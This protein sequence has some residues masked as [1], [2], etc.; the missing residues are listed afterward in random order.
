MSRIYPG[1]PSGS[2]SRNRGGDLAR[3]GSELDL[4]APGVTA[5]GV[6]AFAT[7][8][9]DAREL[10]RI[11][12]I[13]G[14][15]ASEVTRNQQIQLASL[16][17]QQEFAQDNARLAAMQTRAAQGFGVQR[18][19]ERE[20]L[21]LDQIARDTQ[22]LSDEAIAERA[23]Q[24][25]R[26]EISGL[27]QDAALAFG[28]FGTPRLVDALTRRRAALQEQSQRDTINLTLA[29]APNIRTQEQ[30]SQ[31]VDALAAASPGV[32]RTV[33]ANTVGERLLTY[34]ATT[35][36]EADFAN[37]LAMAP[38]VDPIFVAQQRAALGTRQNAVV[39]QTN[40]RFDDELGTGLINARDGL[41]SFDNL[42]QDFRRHWQG[43]VGNE[44]LNAGLERIRSAKKA[45]ATEVTAQAKKIAT[46][47]W[48]ADIVEQAA[49]AMSTALATGGLARVPASGVQQTIDVGGEPVDVSMTYNE[50]R[51]L[52]TERVMESIKRTSPTPEDAFRRQYQTLAENDTE[53][54]AWRQVL[55][56][57]ASVPATS[58]TTTDDKPIPIPVNLQ[59][60]YELYKAMTA[61]DANTATRD[62]H[63]DDRTGRFYDD[64][65]AAMQYVTGGN[66]ASAYQLAAKAERR[67]F[68]VGV[69]AEREEEIRNAASRLDPKGL[70]NA[71]EV[72]NPND[73]R[74]NIYRA[75]KLSMDGMGLAP[76][77][78][79]QHAIANVTGKYAAINGWAVPTNR[80]TVPPNIDSIAKRVV[81]EFVKANPDSG[82]DA[83]DLT[84]MPLGPN[85]R[86]WILYSPSLHAQVGNKVF[87]DD[88]L[89]RLSPIVASEDAAR[90][91][92][93]RRA[94]RELWK[95][96]GVVRDD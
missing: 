41:T 4:I 63:L 76:E 49:E 83:D 50:I 20:A 54:P 94:G 51:Q 86:T 26:S 24:I 80:R 21:I 67:R 22:V 89:A 87:T 28:E 30:F 77:D 71:Q 90:P 7:G 58:L 61:A 36:T 35:G 40:Q 75:A 73:I 66:L 60:G 44:K 25:V 91:S 29:G 9:N 34:A 48:K 1:G 96:L 18:F 6:E 13:A 33:L 17:Q 81:G 11:L 14:D 10:G 93:F 62:R 3:V 43:R 46:N 47:Q 57:G 64:L 92:L 59:S 69:S 52:A 42:E 82:F 55:S 74:E 84:I 2:F 70:F 79:V 68:T 31:T 85:D 23:N 38:G 88:E 37:A 65:D 45:A 53:Y 19:Q 16:R 39:A 95:G 27:D 5:P 72:K 15:A 56:A 32:D 8:L 12:N 78:A